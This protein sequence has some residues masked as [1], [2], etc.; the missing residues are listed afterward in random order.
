MHYRVNE[1]VLLQRENLVSSLLPK[2]SQISKQKQ[3]A[4]TFLQTQRLFANWGQ[5]RAEAPQ[6]AKM[7]QIQIKLS[8][9]AQLIPS[10]DVGIKQRCFFPAESPTLNRD[11]RFVKASRQPPADDS[12]LGQTNAAHTQPSSKNLQCSEVARRTFSLK[13]ELPSS[14]CESTKNC[15]QTCFLRLE[16]KHLTAEKIWKWKLVQRMTPPPR[17]DG[18]DQL[19]N[20][21]IRLFLTFSPVEFG[22]ARRVTAG[23]LGGAPEGCWRQIG[24]ER[25]VTLLCQPITKQKKKDT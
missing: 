4:G 21:L 19:F 11:L 17:L 8:S 10:F 9:P 5:R 24:H 25:A 18:P 13:S 23:Q 16:L 12:L 6:V 22:E 7:I 14:L 15:Q 3:R 1:C 2:T 20:T